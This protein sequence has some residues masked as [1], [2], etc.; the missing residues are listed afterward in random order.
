MNGSLVD[1][2]TTQAGA[3]LES[4]EKMMT[5]LYATEF[6]RTIIGQAVRKIEDSHHATLG[7]HAQ[8]WT[9]L[10]V[11]EILAHPKSYKD[12]VAHYLMQ[13]EDCPDKSDNLRQ[14][15]FT[16]LQE[17]LKRRYDADDNK[18]RGPT[19]LHYLSPYLHTM[20]MLGNA[21]SV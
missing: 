10:G 1:E 17:E 9:L 12:K 11:G 16:A 14:S 2:S 13:A 18:M 8:F 19:R 21:S 5:E 4:I 20:R 3:T 6:S 15:F 7:D